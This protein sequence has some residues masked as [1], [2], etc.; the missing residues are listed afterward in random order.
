MDLS[1]GW[2]YWTNVEANDSDKQFTIL[3]YGINYSCKKLYSTDPPNAELNLGKKNTCSW[4]PGEF[5]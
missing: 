3:Q 2:K 5:F 1:L 4:Q